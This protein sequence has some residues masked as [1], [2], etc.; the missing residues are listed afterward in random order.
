MGGKLKLRT[1]IKAL[2]KIA[3]MEN[4]DIPYSTVAI[5]REIGVSKATVSNYRKALRKEGLIKDKRRVSTGGGDWMVSRQLFDEIPCIAKFTERLKLDQLTPTEYTNRLYDICRTTGTHPDKIIETL[6]SAEIIFSK[7]TEKYKAKNPELMRDRYNRSIRKFLAHN[8]ITLPPNSKV[9]PSGT[10]SSGEYSRVRLDDN[11]V[12]N[13]TAFL[14]KNY[15]DEWGLLFGI[16]HE[17]FARPATMLKWTP[18]V[19]IQYDEVDGKSYE[20]G[21]CSVLEKKTKKRYDKLI[22]QPDVLKHVKELSQNKPIIEGTQDMIS[23]KYAGMLRDYYVEIEKMERDQIYKKGVEAWM[24]SNRP[25]YTIRHSAALM[26][27]RRT[28][29]NLEL[30]AKMGW[31]DTKTLSKFYARTTVNNIMQAGNCY[32]CRPPSAETNEKIFCS[33]SHALAYINGGRK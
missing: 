16:H 27:M 29:F 30:V 17:I 22:F 26:W 20:Y 10:D 12:E 7:F 1:R 32:Y 14:S 11:T 18:N 2:Q 4:S 24:Y 3:E 5:A 13:C 23:A 6:E 31:D 15:G 19:E 33:A 28:G 21:V 25:I 9:M 8:Q